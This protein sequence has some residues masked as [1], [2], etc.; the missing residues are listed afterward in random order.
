LPEALELWGSVPEGATTGPISVET[1]YGIAVTTNVFTV[2][3]RPAPVIN[4]F[5]PTSGYEGM[6]VELWG[7]NLL[8]V[9][10]VTLN[11][12]L[13]ET[14][15]QTDPLGRQFWIHVPTNATTGPITITSKWGSYTT[16]SNF[17]VLPLPAPVVTS[18]EPSSGRPGTVVMLYG[19]N[20]D[21]VRTVRFNGASAGFWAIWQGGI[22][23]TVPRSART[24]PITVEG[25]G[26]T[27]TTEG[28]F[29]LEPPPG[30]VISDFTP[31]SGPVG[32]TVRISGSKLDQI[33]EV[34][35]GDAEAAF[36]FDGDLVA[37][38]PTG[39]TSGQIL[40]Y[41]R[42][43]WAL[44]TTEPFIVIT[45]G[46]LAVSMTAFPLDVQQGDNI[47]YLTLVTNHGPTDVSG[48]VVTNELPLGATVISAS[49]SQGSCVNPSNPVIFTLGVLPGGATA[50]CTVVAT[51]NVSGHVGAVAVVDSGEFD[52]YTA[53]NVAKAF[54]R[55]WGL[56]EL[57]IMALPGRR[58]ELSWPVQSTHFVVQ[59]TELRFPPTD[60][61]ELDVLPVLVERWNVVT[62]DASE[63]SRLYRLLAR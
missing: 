26:G 3:G 4:S 12:V 51:V 36:A 23:A 1:S 40:L 14:I 53:N 18:F 44:S 9:I 43:Y 37:V 8:D 62:D 13:A 57:V 25:K 42:G 6:L 27:N 63:G 48:V 35:F 58:I 49:T 47:T 15:P 46:D 20:L 38:V 60:W 16:S 22:S 31:K 5:E 41:P 52:P 32:T 19:S 2:T 39:A 17:T 45:T 7:S 24:G 30:F 34:W 61:T 33:V 10:S 11:G 56:A 29:V 28:I 54:A 59:T 50:T 55:V 21:L